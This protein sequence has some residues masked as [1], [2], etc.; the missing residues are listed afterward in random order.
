MTSTVPDVRS[1]Q[2]RTLRILVITQVAGSVGIGASISV[3]AVLSQELSGSAS[4]SGM[5]NTMTTFGAALWALPLARVATRGGRRTALALGWALSAIGAVGVLLAAVL[6]SF[7]LMLAAMVLV[8]SGTSANLQSRFAATDLSQPAT[9]A[10]SLSLVVWSSTI[11]A[12]IGPNLTLPGA[13]VAQWL[14]VPAL[15]GPFVF[16]A[17]AGAIA[18]LVLVVALR[19]DPLLT[20]RTLEGADNQSQR[21]NLRAALAAIGASRQAT[22]AIIAVALSHA[23]MVGVMSMTPVHM[24]EHGA[25]LTIIGL[26]ISLHIAG[27][28]ALSPVMGWLADRWGRMPTVLLGQGLLIGAVALAATAGHSMEQVTAG[29]ILLG[30]GWSAATV[31]GS[32]LLAESVG[33]AERPSVQGLSDLV[34]S[35]AGGVGGGLAGVVLSLVAFDGLAWVA[36]LLVLPVLVLAVRNRSYQSAA[37]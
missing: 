32:A 11:G 36:G 34:M 2:R 9:R 1:V 17:V 8:G 4:W 26:T 30:L 23:V 15:S 10:R 22:F 18:A 12:V 20:A 21:R 28:Y 19:P 7:P 13:E 35:L 24:Q 5:G 27:M 33:A 25:S 3:G 14:G 29:L 31:A 37:R 16:C 6:H